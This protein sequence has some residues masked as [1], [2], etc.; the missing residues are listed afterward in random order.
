[1]SGKR[2]NDATLDI[3]YK[4]KSIQTLNMTIAESVDHFSEHPKILNQLQLL[5]DVGLDYLALGQ[6]STTLSGGRGL[7]WQENYPLATG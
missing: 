1:M 2:F 4:G 5:V 6:P 7:S 3:K